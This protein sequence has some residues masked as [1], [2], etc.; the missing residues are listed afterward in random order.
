MSKSKIIDTG[1]KNGAFYLNVDP[2]RDGQKVIGLELVSNEAVEEAISREVAIAGAKIVDFSF[3][4]A[5]LHL[6][7]DTDKDGEKLLELTIDLAEAFDEISS[8]FRRKV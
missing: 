6:K 4:Q 3:Q 5:K 8:N 1:V 7:L 2:N